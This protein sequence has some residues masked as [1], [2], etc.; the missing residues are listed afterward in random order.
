MVINE[1]KIL[2]GR[3]DAVQSYWLNRIFGGI[4]WIREYDAPGAI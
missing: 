2:S 4:K 1:E 3:C